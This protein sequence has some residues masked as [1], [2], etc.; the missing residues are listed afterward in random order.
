MD[1]NWFADCGWGVFCHYLAGAPGFPGADMSAEA[2]SQQV[3]DFDVRGLAE[4]LQSVGAPYFF[5][6][7]GQ[8]SGHFCTDR[9]SV[10]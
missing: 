9:K 7:I 8:G 1:T 4:Q 10:V 5:I 6:T 3:D 2:W